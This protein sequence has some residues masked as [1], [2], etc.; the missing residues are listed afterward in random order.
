MSQAVATHQQALLQGAFAALKQHSTYAEVAHQRR[1]SLL[2]L[3]RAWELWRLAVGLTRARLEEGH[4]AQAA[5]AA[6][7]ASCE[8]L[9]LEADLTQDALTGDENT[10]CRCVHDVIWCHF[11]ATLRKSI[12]RK[13]PYLRSVQSSVC[14]HV[15]QDM[16]TGAVQWA[17]LPVAAHTS[18]EVLPSDQASATKDSEGSMGSTDW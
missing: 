16:S 1:A 10:F 13:N 18:L 14:L 7:L 15:E 6:V 17:V 2:C 4:H 5:C 9:L 8:G 12:A 3:S 11:N